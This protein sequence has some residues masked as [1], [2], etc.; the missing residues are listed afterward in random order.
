MTSAQSCAAHGA[1]KLC[2]NCSS[3]VSV[4]ASVGDGGTGVGVA[5]AAFGVGVGGTG[6]GVAFTGLDV[7]IAFVRAGVAVGFGGCVGLAVGVSTAFLETS[8][9]GSKYMM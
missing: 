4:G 1:C 8:T 7:E 9:E 5:G 3:K 2:A 6:V